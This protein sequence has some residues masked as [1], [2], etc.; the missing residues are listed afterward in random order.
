MFD[1]SIIDEDTE[2]T[3][4]AVNQAEEVI[5]DGNAYEISV[6]AHTYE[7]PLII[8][9]LNESEPSSTTTSFVI[10][11]ANF[12]GIID[13]RDSSIILTIFAQKSTSDNTISLTPEEM[14]MDVNQNGIIDPQDATIILTYYTLSSAGQED[15]TFVEYLISIK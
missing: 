1:Y 9:S 2:L 6:D 14:S 7:S 11:D 5:D 8:D 12:D 10:G 4:S 3:S 15:L 13:G